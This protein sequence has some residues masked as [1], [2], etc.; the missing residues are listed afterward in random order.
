MLLETDKITQSI[1]VIIIVAYTM[2][3]IYVQHD[4]ILPVDNVL[5]VHAPSWV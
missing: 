3:E 4:S 5:P 1:R 2:I